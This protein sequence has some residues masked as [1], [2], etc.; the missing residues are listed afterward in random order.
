MR[1]LIVLLLVTI[2]TVV[3]YSQPVSSF[4]PNRYKLC[5]GS[6]LMLYNTSTGA[7]SFSWFMDGAYLTKAIDTS[8]VLEDSCYRMVAVILVA[9]DSKLHLADTSKAF[10]EVIGA[11]YFHWTGDFIA[12]AGD[13]IAL[14]KHPESEST[15]WTL[16]PPQNIIQG[17]DTCDSLVF[18]FTSG[19]AHINRK[20]NYAGGCYDVV[21]FHYMCSLDVAEVGVADDVAIYPNPATDVLNISIKNQKLYAWSLCDLQGRVLGRATVQGQGKVDTRAYPAGIYFLVLRSG[22]EVHT[23][24]IVVE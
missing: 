10:I 4:H 19:G 6:T 14:G 21:S 13:T 8:L 18:V 17:C 2:A 15:E 20:N 7:D 3:A 22:G 23:R 5:S 11:C 24:K 12:C 9:M 1:A 16:I